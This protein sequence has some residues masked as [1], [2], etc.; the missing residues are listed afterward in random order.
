MNFIVSSTELQRHIATITGI[1]P[2]K[3][4]LPIVQYIL[5]EV[6][7]GKLRLTATDLENSIQ[8]QLKIE[9]GDGEFKVALPPK[10]LQD[11]LKALHEQPLHIHTQDN[12]IRI[13]TDNAEYKIN[14]MTGADFP[15]VQ[16]ENP[17][18]SSFSLPLHTLVKAIHKTIFA[19][20]K[21]E[22]KPA[23]SGVYMNFKKDAVTF[24]ATDAHCLVRYRRTDISV[25]NEVSFILPEKALKQALVAA[26]N[27]AED[28][29][30]IDYNNRNAIFHLGSTLL[31]CRLIDARFPEYENVIPV[32]S[33]N[34]A[35]II[36]RDLLATIRR[37]DIYSNK[38]THLGRYKFKG[39]L[40]EVQAEDHD[41]ANQATENLNCLYEGE[42]LEI[43]FNVKLMSEVIANIDTD[44]AVL[45][46]DTP[47]RAA[48]VVPSDQEA[49]EQLLMLLMPVMLGASY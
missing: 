18:A 40:L 16:L 45:E 37:L 47:G 24:V 35:I 21:D 5:F 9:G 14:G 41:F 1:V 7:D 49:G 44:E 42:E 31:S 15:G 39:N 22:L 29:V 20:S 46:L 33:P 12:L 38:I 25:E 28:T 13:V 23:M 48:I 8:T 30:R 17:D 26:A 36:K 3:S 11:T 10:I 4:V 43:G 32:S 6:K 19:V 2:A 34:R 27:T